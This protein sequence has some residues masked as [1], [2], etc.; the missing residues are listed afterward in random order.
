VRKKRAP[1][2]LPTE[3]VRGRCTVCFHADS[4]SINAELADGEPYRMV[5]AKY[6]GLDF[7]AVHRHHHN[8]LKQTKADVHRT[9]RAKNAF[10]FGEELLK[11]YR[12][13]VKM[14]DAVEKWLTDP[15][16]PDELDITPRD[17]EI[18]VIYLDYNHRNE[19]GKPTRKKAKL[20]DL[21][22]QAVPDGCRAMEVRSLAV[23]NRK[24]YLEAF[25]ALTDRLDQLGKFHDYW[26]QTPIQPASQE[27]ERLRLAIEARAKENDVSYEEE[28]R[29]F[30]A[31]PV[32]ENIRPEVRT[33]LVSDLVQ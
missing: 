28:L 24:L 5:A 31:L 30:L 2:P 14:L 4:K 6:D 7:R 10:E 17:T 33:L 3:W 18:L 19:R 9:R 12:Q 8:C 32:A 23:D 16:N 27:T 1:K 22:K 11:R 25:K 13:S 26:K 21:L 29:F 20:S 15:E